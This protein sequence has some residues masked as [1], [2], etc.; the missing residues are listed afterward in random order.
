M[1]YEEF[2][3]LIINTEKLHKE[4]SE[5]YSMGF[6]FLE[7]K[8]PLETYFDT[9]IDIALSSN[10]DEEG[11][12]W[13]NWYMFENDFGKKDWSELIRKSTDD[14]PVKKDDGYGAHDEN[15]KPICYDIKSLW[16]HVQQ[17]K[18]K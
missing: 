6:D 13:I 8:Y 18:I 5:L 16:E 2:E 1:N 17:F 12:D 14:E 15:G 7:G 3:K 4:F 10:F 9:I 11:V